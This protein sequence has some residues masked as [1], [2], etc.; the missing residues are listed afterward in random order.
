MLKGAYYRC[1][2]NLEIARI[3][4][5]VQS[6]VIANG[7]ELERLV[8]ELTEEQRIYDIDEFLKIQIIHNGVFVV[9]KPEIRKSRTLE[10]HGIEPD[11][12]VFERSGSSQ[13]CYIVELKDGHEFDTK[14]SQKE[15]QNLHT[16][17]SKNAMAFQYY[18]SYCKICGF[19]AEDKEQIV[20]GFKNKIAYAQAMTGR[21]LFELL[22][23]DY[24]AAVARRAQDRQENVEYLIQ[25]ILAV[26][27]V[28][29]RGG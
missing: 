1:F 22:Q 26:D 23:L 19:N 21:E 15:H 6:L 2:G 29:I 5:S 27:A 24:D 14:S 18:N 25:S 12:I 17:L 9:Y 4:S 20:K 13:S 11:F 7:H 3:L 10:G 8:E 16:F 28:K